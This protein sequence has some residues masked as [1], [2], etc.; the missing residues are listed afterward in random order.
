[1]S[2]R[3]EV[4][5]CT[6]V[7]TCIVLLYIMIEII[8]MER[9]RYREGRAPVSILRRRRRVR[10]RRRRRRRRETVLGVVQHADVALAG[11]DAVVA[12]IRGVRAALDERGGALSAILPRA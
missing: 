4:E 5:G 12:D 11:L 10:R 3:P 6:V 2:A 1:M 9:R 8:I 7:I